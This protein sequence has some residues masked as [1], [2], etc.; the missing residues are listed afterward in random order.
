MRE[1]ISPTTAVMAKG[2]G[3]DV[4]LR[5]DG[6]ISGGSNG[7]VV[8]HITPEAALGGPLAVVKNGDPIKIDAVK[9][10]LSLDLPK[11][12]IEKRLAKWKAPAA[13]YTRGVLSKYAKTVATASK[14][15]VTD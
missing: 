3:K 14:G 6:R 12:E 13:R 9:H 11:G 15:A 4:A 10:T 2:V 7:F 8:G 1:T 5:T